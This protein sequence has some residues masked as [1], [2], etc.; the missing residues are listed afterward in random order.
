M[1][2]TAVERSARSGGKENAIDTS[3][4]QLCPHVMC[5]PLCVQVPCAVCSA[6]NIIK[7]TPTLPSRCF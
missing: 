7:Y 4:I 5:M 1:E 3:P 6:F 2:S